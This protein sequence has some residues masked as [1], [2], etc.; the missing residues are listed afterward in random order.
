MFTS[1]S[2]ETG[3][4]R[5]GGEHPKTKAAPPPQQEKKKPKF[6][7]FRKETRGKPGSSGPFSEDTFYSMRD[8][9]DEITDSTR[10]QK[11]VEFH[12]ETHVEVMSD[13]KVEVFETSS[14]NVS[15][16]PPKKQTFKHEQKVDQKV[17]TEPKAEKTHQVSRTVKQV[18]EVPKQAYSRDTTSE[19]SKVTTAIVDQES[20]KAKM[21]TQVKATPIPK[22][23]EKI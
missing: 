22:P 15:P 19:K 7:E 21:A 17:R 12:S 8:E 14:V 16:Q 11:K 1:R 23:E 3:E 4:E 18:R 5:R 9:S 6:E 20:H 10:T 2:E 13:K